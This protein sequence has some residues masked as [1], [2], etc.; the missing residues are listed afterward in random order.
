MIREALNS[1]EVRPTVSNLISE[2]IDNNNLSKDSKDFRSPDRMFD[3][4]E[5]VSPTTLYGFSL[6]K[7]HSSI[8]YSPLKKK[9][10]NDFSGVIDTNLQLKVTNIIG[11]HDI[12]PS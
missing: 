6:D 7:T 5:V 11:S 12:T 3:N 2:S 1:R 9:L 10:Y 8:P 4:Q